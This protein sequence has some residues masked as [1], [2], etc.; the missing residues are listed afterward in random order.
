MLK[1]LVFFAKTIINC[2][3][4][5]K[6]QE[7]ENLM[8][9]HQLAVLQ[10]KAK[11]SQLKRADRFFFVLVSRYLQN[12]KDALIIVKPETVIRWQ[13]ADLTSYYGV[14]R[15]HLSLDKDSFELLRREI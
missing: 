1:S 4:S 5:H 14:S 9:R 7:L 3:R 8:L 15:T 2:F 6:Q 10:R 13:R 12:W 11:R